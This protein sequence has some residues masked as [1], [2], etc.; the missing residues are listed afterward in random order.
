MGLFDFFKSN[1]SKLTKI[2]KNKDE[3]TEM[4]CEAISKLENQ[5]ILIDLAKNDPDERIRFS[6]ALKVKDVNVLKNIAKNDSSD[7]A[8]AAL[9]GIA[10]SM[11]PNRESILADLALNASNSRVRRDAEMH[12]GPTSSF[13]NKIYRV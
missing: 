4:R 13:N 5:S 11:I 6:A 2:A 12:L 1:Q 3:S 8:L 10:Y 9:D 7:A